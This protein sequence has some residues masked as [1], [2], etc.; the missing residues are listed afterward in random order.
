MPARTDSG[1][2]AGPSELLGPY[3]L[4]PQLVALLCQVYWLKPILDE[5]EQVTTLAAMSDRAA[6]WRWFHFDITHPPLHILSLHY[7]IRFIGHSDSSL[8]AMSMLLSVVTLALFY[9]L[10]RRFLPRSGAALVCLLQG[11]STFYVF[12]AREARPFSLIALWG[13]ATI[14]LLTGIDGPVTTRRALAYFLLCTALAY[15]SYVGLLLITCELLWIAFRIAAGRAKL[16]VAGVAGALSICPW[17]W[18][19]MRPYNGHLMA[20]LSR[21]MPGTYAARW[22]DIGAFYAHAV[23]GTFLHHAAYFLL[24]VAAVAI[25]P[26]WR[27]LL[28]E[29]KLQLIVVCATFPVVTLH[30]IA[31]FSPAYMWA[32]RHL[33]VSAALFV[34][35]LVIGIF[36]HRSA[37]L[38]VTLIAALLVASA[39]TM[40]H[41]VRRYPWGDCCVTRLER[42]VPA[43][44]FRPT[45]N[46]TLGASG[47]KNFS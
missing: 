3:F 47:H 43:T 27:R 8:R 17:A 25:A 30:I 11:A 13:I 34:L 22:A 45:K 31:R 20:H 21:L 44:A 29:P 40:V 10:A 7:W 14:Y 19:M 23:A 12:Y 33:I 9:L 37:V 28:A 1:P 36:E 2:S 24:P 41:S 5:D 16:L 39:L 42:R 26:A 15:T 35:V 32:T 4:V 46:R 6:L 38:R 18:T